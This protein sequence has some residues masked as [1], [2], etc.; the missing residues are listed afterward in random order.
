MPP[1]RLA[2]IR[3]AHRDRIDRA[4]ARAIARAD[5]R[6]MP[7]R[8]WEAGCWLVAHGLA[9]DAPCAGE[10]W[11]NMP[12]AEIR[13]YYDALS[14]TAMRQE[15]QAGERAIFHGRD[16]IWIPVGEWLEAAE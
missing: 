12:I 6:G 4:A 13:R 10:L 3:A 7:H 11:F 16:P 5:A 9:D 2:A 14:P 1:H 15:I 8:L